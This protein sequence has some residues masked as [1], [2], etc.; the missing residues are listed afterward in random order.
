MCK[1]TLEMKKGDKI[2]INREIT[3]IREEEDTIIIKIDMTIKDK[4]LKE[5]R[6]KMIIIETI[7]T[8]A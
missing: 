5:I 7:D 2:H 3:M 4:T 1:A 6:K 8:K